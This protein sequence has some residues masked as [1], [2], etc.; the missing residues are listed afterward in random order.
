VLAQARCERFHVVE[1]LAA[2][3]STKR[4]RLHVLRQTL[5]EMFGVVEPLAASFPEVRDSF[6]ERRAG[7][8]C[9]RAS[10]LEGFAR[11]SMRSAS[12]GAPTAA[13]H[14]DRAA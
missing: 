3:L 11:G 13:P 2:T 9:G 14:A 7:I 10:H 6:V 12:A 5:W 1:P 4:G 8:A